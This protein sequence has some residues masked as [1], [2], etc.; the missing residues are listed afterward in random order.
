MKGII[1]TLATALLGIIAFFFYGLKKNKEAEQVKREAAEARNL[2]YEKMAEA[3]AEKQES[4]ELKIE[5]DLL[6]SASKA[7]KDIHDAVLKH[8]EKRAADKEKIDGIKDKTEL[9]EEE[10]K[11]AEE[12]SKDP[13]ANSD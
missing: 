5:S 6:K 8:T 11:V 1:A 9:S 13:F 2:A 12:L 10:K 7:A 3:E 4:A